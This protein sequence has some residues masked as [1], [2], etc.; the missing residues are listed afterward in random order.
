MACRNV[1]ASQ[2]KS[3]IGIHV[4]NFVIYSTIFS[5][6]NAPGFAPTPHTQEFQLVIGRFVVNILAPLGQKLTNCLSLSNKCIVQL[7]FKFAL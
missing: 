1:I 7:V 4:K 3:D 6:E 2:Q 5:E